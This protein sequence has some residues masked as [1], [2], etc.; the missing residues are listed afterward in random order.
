M[1]DAYGVQRYTLS[2]KNGNTQLSPMA[3]GSA[4]NV[5]DG[6]VAF[7]E[8]KVFGNLNTKRNALVGISRVHWNDVVTKRTSK[9]IKLL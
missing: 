7:V 2:W 8:V 4:R 1:C 9:L 6:A 3:C 5:R